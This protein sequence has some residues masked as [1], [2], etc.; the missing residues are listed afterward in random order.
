MTIRSAPPGPPT[1][2]R[3]F[4][5]SAVVFVFLILATLG[6]VAHLIFK[7]FSHQVIT[8][9]LLNGLVELKKQWSESAMEQEKTAITPQGLEFS[10]QIPIPAP[11]TP[12]GVVSPAENKFRTQ[13]IA[14]RGIV[15]VIT[16]RDRNGNVVG[17]AGARR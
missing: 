4:V 13:R 5:I 7:D 9:N 3:S 11:S 15:Q 8:R 14:Y 6:V 1:F 16:I 12:P 10:Q 2:R 17:A